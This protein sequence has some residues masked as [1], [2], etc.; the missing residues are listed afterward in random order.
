M[1]H[2]MVCSLIAPPQGGACID[3]VG[4]RQLVLSA[5]TPTLFVR[6]HLGSTTAGPNRMSERLR[7]MRW[8]CNDVV[9]CGSC[10]RAWLSSR[11]PGSFGP[12]LQEG[13]CILE[14]SADHRFSRR[15]HQHLCGIQHHGRPGL[16]LIHADGRSRPVSTRLAA[17]NLYL[18]TCHRT[19]GF[20]GRRRQAK[21]FIGVWRITSFFIGRRQYNLSHP[22]LP[23]TSPE[24]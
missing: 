1:P 9:M 16:R 20:A 21:R 17:R 6:F 2:M 3:D 14:A 18:V 24:K 13:N 22:C 8:A 5:H 7:S 19:Y 11:L 15:R 12:A 4:M 10:G 23:D